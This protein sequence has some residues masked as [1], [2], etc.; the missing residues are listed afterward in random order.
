MRKNNGGVYN[1]HNH[2]GQCP[3]DCKGNTVD[4]TDTGRSG[5]GIARIGGL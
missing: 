3:P 2:L 4:I 1:Q 5:D